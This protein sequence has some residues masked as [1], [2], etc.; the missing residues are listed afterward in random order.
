MTLDQATRA[1]TQAGGSLDGA[2]G[3]VTGG[4]RGLGAEICRELA[5][6]GMHVIAADVRAEMAE[7]L[8]TELR[9]NGL[10][11]DALTLDVT[12]AEAIEAAVAQ[13][14]HDLGGLDVL[15]NN[16]GIDRTVS[17]EEMGVDDWDRIMA[18]NLRA[19][20][21]L[22]RAVL[23]G[24]RERGHGHIVNIVSTASKRAWANASA[25]HASKWGLLGFSHALHVE[26]RQFGVK[27]TALVAGGMR[28]DFLFERFPDLDPGLLQDPRNVAQ[29]VRF[30]LSQ[31]AETVIPE[32][33]VLPMRETSWP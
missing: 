29:A 30:A 4:A 16:A 22:S 33:I 13:L 26:A 25:Y 14:D 11:A 9:A 21:V 3:L 20:F 32:M 17:V 27:V 28:T 19:P 15:V 2:V 10:T 12:D 7:T 18:V 1:V 8:C 6:A 23:P 31:P 24:M 5:A